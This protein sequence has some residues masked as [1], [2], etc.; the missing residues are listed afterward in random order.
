MSSNQAK[1]EDALA[2]AKLVPSGS[3][4]CDEWERPVRCVSQL[5]ALEI[6]IDCPGEPKC[7]S[8]LKNHTKSG[9][10]SEIERF[11]TVR[12]R[13]EPVSERVCVSESCTEA[14]G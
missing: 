9:R 8:E 1:A 14:K 6:R 5:A 12:L 7:K 11:N 10:P 2:Q 4:N 13:S 3:V